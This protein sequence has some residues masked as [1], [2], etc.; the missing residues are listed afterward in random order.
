VS[1][2]PRELKIA[3][4]LD[5]R[6]QRGLFECL[7][8]LRGA[9]MRERFELH[10]LRA[11]GG[12]GAIFTVVDRAN[13]SSRLLGKL[14]IVPWHRPI[15]LTSKVL[16]TAREI[17]EQEARIL[18]VVGCPYLPHCE[19]LQQLDNPL[20]ETE[21]GG[22]FARPEPCLV[23][24]RIGGQDLDTWLCR[25]HR[26]ELEARRLRA[27]LDRVVV[28]VLQ[29]LTDLERRGWVYADLRPGNL[30]VVGRPR[31][32]IRLIDAGGVVPADGSGKRFPHVPSYLPPE[33]FWDE[34]KGRVIV[35]TR[36]L[37]AA[38]AGRALY[39]VA[40]GAAPQ[41][42]KEIDSERM[43][44]S[45][46][47]PAVAQVIEALARGGHPDCGSGLQALADRAQRRVRGAASVRERS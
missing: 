16:R 12:E 21:R 10:E 20:V 18:T 36:A 14:P 17:V 46:V 5:A 42:A 29:A 41:A 2:T 8:R 44:E 15:E 40:T 35:A 43:A 45:R 24:E 23:M 3:R 34:Q 28:G 37:H 27:T 6:G 4:R 30:R 7:V 31:R 9:R 26:G 13:P 32:R 47:S 39:E 25:V 11:V 19:G 22:E 1:L 33:V 38:M